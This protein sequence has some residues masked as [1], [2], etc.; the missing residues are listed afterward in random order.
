[1][2][3][4][5]TL[6]ETCAPDCVHFC[7]KTVL[8]LGRSHPNTH[9]L[10]NTFRFNLTYTFRGYHYPQSRLHI[11]VHKLAYNQ[12]KKKTL[13]ITREFARELSRFQVFFSIKAIR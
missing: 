9:K 5:N 13:F 11:N 4:S 6:Q 8:A 1:M 3:V 12:R 10:Y 2:V 7:Q